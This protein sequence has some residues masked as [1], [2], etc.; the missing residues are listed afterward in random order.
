MAKDGMIVTSRTPALLLCIIML[1]STLLA[2]LAI[3]PAPVAGL[4]TDVSTSEDL[5]GS[6]QNTAV[7][8]KVVVE[9]GEIHLAQELRPIHDVVWSEGNAL[10]MVVDPRD[11]KPQL[12]PAS[13]WSTRGGFDANGDYQHS[14]V[15]DRDNN[16]V[17]VYGGRH[18]SG[19]QSFIHNNLW[20]YDPGANRW[21]ELTPVSRFKWFH[22]AVWAEAYHMM[23]VYGGLSLID[24]TIYL[25]NETLVYWPANDTWALMAPS[26]FGGRIGHSMVWDNANNQMLVAGGTPDGNFSNSTNDLY[27]FVPGTN[28]WVDLP[29]FAANMARGGSAAVWDTQNEQLIMFGGRRRGN[30]MTSVLSYKPSTGSWVQRTNAPVDRWFHSMSWDPVNNKAYSF[31]GLSSSNAISARFYEYNPLNDRWTPLEIGIDARFWTAFV[32][33]PVRGIGLNFAGAAT[34]GNPP[35]TSYNDVMVYRTDVPF[36]EEGWLTSSI[37]DIGGVLDVGTLSWTP[38]AQPSACGPDAVKFQVASSSSLEVPTNFVGP[39][40]TS[41]TYYTNPSGTEVGDHHFAA[42]KIAYRMFFHTDDNTISPTIDSVD[43]E[44]YRYESKG[45]YTSPIVDLGQAQSTLERVTYRSERPTGTNPNLVKVV[46]KIRTSMDSEMRGASAWEEIVKDDRDLTIPYGRFFQFKVEIFTDTQGRHLT[47]IFKGITVEYN[48]PPSLTFS[49]LDRHEGDRTSWFTYAVTYTDIDNDEPTIKNVYIDGTAYVMSSPDLTFTDGAAY[50][51]TTR[52][53]L[54]THD[55]WFEF[56]DGKNR[57]RDPPVAEYI[58][59]VVVNRAPVPIID[60]PQ[61]GVRVTPDEPVEFSASSSSDPD[62]DKLSYIWT[63]SIEGVLDTHAAFITKLS[64]GNHIITLEVT[65]EMGEKNETQIQILSKPYIPVLEVRDIYLD[66]TEPIEMD[67]VTINAVV[68]NDGEV[69]ATPAIIEFMVDD[70]V[71]DE[72]RE[73]LDVGDRLT[74][75][76]HWT[77]AGDRVFLGIRARW[78]SETEPDDEMFKS[79]DVQRNSPPEINADLSDTV[80]IK[81]KAISFVNN[82]TTDPEGDK[83]T[84]LWEFGDGLTST[85]A[86]TQHIYAAP[87][88]Y[89][90]NLTVTDKRGDFSREQFIVTIKKKPKDESPGFAS[91]LVLLALAGSAGVATWERKR[92]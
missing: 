40:G 12:G 6:G 16:Q 23:I 22:Q 42:G 33:D 15:W 65:D 64:E 28:S 52:L 87:G 7:L 53:P 79:V 58:G 2:A 3:V 69:E 71:V 67:R 88:T 13:H 24:S 21:D 76:F 19:T 27:A 60:F 85:D 49:L 68:Y 31:G 80:V 4:Q 66:K 57:V 29:N 44:V 47:P 90:V 10:N 72:V 63:S 39:D 41:N 74:A 86:T 25:L 70:L 26:P 89:F 20:A 30:A 83:M 45:T 56:S 59:P 35:I 77:A 32:W 78:G 11:S 91:A 36:V 92:R 51:F 8:D 54:G 9:D 18:D 14:A 82:G 73:N 61:T 37:Y 50:T 34:V 43:L 81:G 84:Y 55:Y 17:L 5:L 46:V 48:S 1:S 75:T 38:T 62:D